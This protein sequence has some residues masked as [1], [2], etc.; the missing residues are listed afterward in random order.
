M[1]DHVRMGTRYGICVWGGCGVGR[2]GGHVEEQEIAM[3]MIFVVVT[4]ND[5]SV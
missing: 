5:P 4:R 3:S 2:V 1:L